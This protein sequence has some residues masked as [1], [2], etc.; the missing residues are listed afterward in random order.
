MPALSLAPLGERFSDVRQIA[1][2]RGGGLGDLLFA[3]PA[4]EALAAA[5]PQAGVTV[6]GMPGHRALLA[7]RPGTSVADVEVLPVSEGVRP[8]SAD[9]DAVAEFLDRM[10][11]RSFDLAV[12]AHGGGRNSNPFLL[13]LGARHT[14]GTAT[15]D[16]APL[17][18]TLPH[19]FYQPEVL[20]WLEVAGMAGATPVTLEPTLGVRP[21]ERADARRLLPAHRPHLVIHP[22]ATDARRR[23]SVHRFAAVA[24]AVAA[25]GVEVHVVG[26]ASEVAT[27]DALVSA[28][29]AALPVAARS[30]V[31]SLAGQL[32]LGRLAGVLAAADVVLANDS[33]PR[34]LAQ[35]VGT[36][37]VG[38][39]WF[40]N[41]INA[42]PFGRGRHR[43]LLG[44]V[45]RCPQCGVDVTQVGWTAPR[46]AHDPSFVGDVDVAD[47][48][49]EVCDLLAGT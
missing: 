32:S 13:R 42:A 30:S 17:E 14:I 1:V 5:Y 38:I 7:G 36:R 24:A 15:S 11:A 6:L 27:A 23:W 33:G 45:T 8:G 9:P 21:D 37:T 35:A 41:A 16:A 48:L 39:Y 46:C 20:R 29:Q 25:D 4:V 26:D 47:V 2:L 3:L 40:G 18:R 12:Q 44:W 10:R 28:A 43:V 19:R 49:A 22:G 31:T 34:H